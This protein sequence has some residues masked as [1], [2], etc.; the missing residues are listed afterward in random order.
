MV[1]LIALGITSAYAY[2]LYA[3]AANL[4]N[5]SAGH[6]MDFFWELATLIV[7]MLL[8][9]WIEMRAVSGAG[10]ALER[11]AALLP[12]K[13]NVRQ[14]DGSYVETELPQVRVG[15]TVMVKAGEKVP[16]DGT[17]EQGSTTVD[18]SLVTGESRAVAKTAG[19][20][21]VGGSQNGEGTVLVK[22]SATARADTSLRLWNSYRRPRARRRKRRRGPTRLPGLCSTLQCS[23]GLRPLSCGT[24]LRLI[25]GWR[26]RAWS[27]C[28]SS[29]VRMAHRT[30]HPP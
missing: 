28:S 15:Q 20:A 10:D 29:P 7:I 12:S 6:V 17:I 22:V 9:H 4:L 26:L 2:S 8:G 14:P 21:V 24:S 23:S 13:A 25:S 27:R 5:G 19:D 16:T 1:T 3:F 11:M 18:E 30:R